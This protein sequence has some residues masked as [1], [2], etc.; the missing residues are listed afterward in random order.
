[1]NIRKVDVL[2]LERRVVRRPKLDEGP[3]IFVGDRPSVIE[4]RQVQGL[5]FLSQP[6]GPHAESHPAVGQ[7]VQGGQSLC[8]DDGVA[9]GH[10][11][12]A[13]AQAQSGGLACDERQH[14][15]LVEAGPADGPGV[16][17]FRVV[18]IRR[19][20]VLGEDYVV[21]TDHRI[22][23][24][25]LAPADQGPHGLWCREGT[26]A[27]YCETVFH[28]CSPMSGLLLLLIKQR[29][30]VSGECINRLGACQR[31]PFRAHS[32]KIDQIV[33]SRTERYG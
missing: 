27:G 16:D 11:H 18:G 31:S 13:G 20:D 1:M 14:R 28:A 2:A 8:S 23:P 21:W 22:E 4:R 15:E 6:A 3:D 29:V 5:E 24:Q 10:D 30:S 32:D 26:A 7:H 33:P 19:G 25:V 17:G 9:V 12:D